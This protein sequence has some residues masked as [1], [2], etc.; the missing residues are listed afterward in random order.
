MTDPLQSQRDVHTIHSGSSEQAAAAT[1][2][3]HLV[4]AYVQNFNARNAQGLADVFAP[5][6]LTVH[7]AEPS[8]DVTAAAPFLERMRALWPRELY[9]TLRRFS[10]RPLNERISEAWAELVIGVPGE[11]PLAAEVVIY[12]ASEGRV[13]QLTVY[14][15]MHPNHADYQ[16]GLPS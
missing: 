15:L 7:P 12:R 11:A 6:L 10:E 4:C 3:G 5:D 14:K 1:E 2:A 8:L 9:Y 16:P 13:V